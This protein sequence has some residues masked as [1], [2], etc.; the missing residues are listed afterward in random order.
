MEEKPGERRGKA[1]KSSRCAGAKAWKCRENPRRGRKS[2]RKKGKGEKNRAGARVIKRGRTGKTRAE[3]EKP[4]ERR[5]KARKSSRC[6]GDKARKYRE[7]PRRGGK[8]WRKKGKGEKKRAGARVIKRGSAGRTRVNVR[9]G[10]DAQ[11]KHRKKAQ[12]EN[13]T[14]ETERRL[15]Y[16]EE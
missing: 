11:R 5:G 14:N 7:N 4:G 9:N 3:E 1:R 10:D 6:A 8:S 15:Y 13:A 2:G 12:K 16:E